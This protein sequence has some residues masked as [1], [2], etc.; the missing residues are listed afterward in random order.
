[1]VC[2]TWIYRSYDWEGVFGRLGQADKIDIFVFLPVLVI[3]YFFVRAHRWFLLLNSQGF[4]PKYFDIWLATVISIGLANYTPFQLGEVV[5]VELI[6]KNCQINRSDGYASLAVE[7]MLDLLSL[8]LIAFFGLFYIAKESVSEIFGYLFVFG[9][10]LFVFICIFL[11]KIL[12]KKLHRFLSSLIGCFSCRRTILSVVV[13]TIFAWILVVLC[14]MVCLKSVQVDLGFFKVAVMMGVSSSVGIA[15]FIP[16][17]VGVVELSNT[18]ILDLL[19]YDSLA[20]QSASIIVRVYGLWMLLFAMPP[21]LY[22]YFKLK[23]VR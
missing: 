13:L 17:G 5:K 4:Y 8:A 9:V 3:L 12:Q 6:R 23:P 10:I 21:A 16:G 1:M 14:W 15:T 19:G 11:R 22:W 2:G 20:A 18:R 7:R